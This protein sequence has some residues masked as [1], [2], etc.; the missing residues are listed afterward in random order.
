MPLRGIRS[1]LLGLAPTKPLSVAEPFNDEVVLGVNADRDEP[2][3]TDGGKAM[4]RLASYYDDIA[5][6]GDDL[7]PIDRHSRVA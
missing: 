7:F 2:F 4:R 5:R 3:V 1:G 6:T